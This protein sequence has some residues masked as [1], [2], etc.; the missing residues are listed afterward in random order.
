M[1]YAVGQR[2]LA[3]LFFNRALTTNAPG[4]INTNT[5][6]WEERAWSM[7][8]AETVGH[9]R[10]CCLRWCLVGGGME[11]VLCLAVL[12]LAVLRLS[13]CGLIHSYPF[14]A[15]RPS[16]VPAQQQFLGALASG[17][18]GAF[19]RHP[20]LNNMELVMEGLEIMTY[21]S[22]R[23]ARKILSSRVLGPKQS[24]PLWNDS[25]LCSVYFRDGECFFP[26]S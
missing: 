17:P 26:K 23:Y 4:L 8:T 16:W 10:L 3:A 14:N 1:L 6:R 9:P 2:I 5:I 18:P 21:S 22:D 15:V 24:R 7:V 20:N 12:C 13:S 25:A 19:S 11:P